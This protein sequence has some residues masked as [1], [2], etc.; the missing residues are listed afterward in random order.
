[1]KK[2]PKVRKELQVSAREA[3]KAPKETRERKEVPFHANY[4]DHQPSFRAKA[5]QD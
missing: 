1:M 5:R 2:D 4:L 3:N